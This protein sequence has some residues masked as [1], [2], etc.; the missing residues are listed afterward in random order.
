MNRFLFP[1]VLVCAAAVAS[2]CTEARPADLKPPT[3]VKVQSVQAFSV[4]TGLHYSATIRPAAQVELAFKNGGFVDSIHQTGGRL[5]DKGNPVVKGTVLARVRQAD[6]QDRLDQANSQLREARASLE[7]AKARAAENRARLERAEQDFMRA[8]K[9]Y[10]AQSLTKPNFDLARADYDAA[11]AKLESSMADID[12]AQSRIAASEAVA[13]DAMLGVQDTAI[14]APMS[15]TILERKIEIGSLA[16]AGRVAFVLAD[17]S[18]VKAVFGVPDLEIQ[19]IESGM[20]LNLT[21]DALPGQTFTGRVTS[22]S[23]AADEKSR[24]FETE[25]TIPNPKGLLKSGMIASVV[26][27]STSSKEKLSAVPLSAIVRSKENAETYAVFVV[28]GSDSVARLRTVELGDAFGNMI[29]VKNG[30]KIGES[31][32]TIGATLVHDGA[33][34]QIVP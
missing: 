14:V 3:P 22:I 4:N 16:S 13:A 23:P 29:M 12:A 8:E 24:I 2:G 10:S 33:A 9:L 21:S 32:I 25:V 30:L 19:K 27:G 20:L 18:A 17:V 31:V 7:S 26:V 34:V 28:E 11:R 5:I 15:G 6:F 1:I